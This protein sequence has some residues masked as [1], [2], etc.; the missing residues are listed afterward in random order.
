MVCCRTEMKRALARAIL[1]RHPPLNSFVFFAC[2][3]ATH[4]PRQ[5]HVLLCHV[6]T[7]LLLLPRRTC[8]A[9]EKPRP[10]RMEEARTSAVAA[11]ISSRCSYT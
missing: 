4:P 1:M 8:M 9:L 2:T 5:R 7:P 10:A 11:S 3:T 6:F